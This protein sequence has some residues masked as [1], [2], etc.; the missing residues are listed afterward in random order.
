[1]T[2]LARLD[3]IFGKER[4]HDR[5]AARALYARIVEAARREHFYR[6]R[7]VPDTLDGRFELLALHTVL[8]CRRFAA[9]GAAGAGPGQRLFD[10]MIEDLDVNLRELGV[11]DPSL[12]RRVKE[13]ARAF[14]GRRDD[15]AAALDGGDRDALERAVETA[16]QMLDSQPLDAI[17]AAT[18]RFPDPAS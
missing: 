12:G 3:T 13:M 5:A 2:L 17:A 7:G 14:Y 16:A 9:E 4:R 18:V 11:N 8:V 6:A 10:A 15:Y 1:M